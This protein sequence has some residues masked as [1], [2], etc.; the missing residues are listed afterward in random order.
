[1]SS[2]IKSDWFN[3][4]YRSQDI[5]PVIPNDFFRA[6]DVAFRLTHLLAFVVYQ[7]AMGQDRFV[8]G[9]ALGA[10]AN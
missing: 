4:A 2:S 3:A 1:M 6:D 7:E 10:Q 9:F 8:G 5:R